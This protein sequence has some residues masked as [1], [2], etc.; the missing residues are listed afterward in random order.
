[1]LRSR[2]LQSFRLPNTFSHTIMPL[3]FIQAMCNSDVWSSF[4][5]HE[6]LLKVGVWLGHRKAGKKSVDEKNTVL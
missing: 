5:R 1:M 4:Q 2:G 3:P 6:G